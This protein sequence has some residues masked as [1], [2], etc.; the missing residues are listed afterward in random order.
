MFSMIL[1]CIFSA[2]QAEAAFNLDDHDD[3]GWVPLGLGITL[4]PD[5]TVKMQDIIDEDVRNF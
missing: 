3:P 2:S 5:G 4:Q 1:L